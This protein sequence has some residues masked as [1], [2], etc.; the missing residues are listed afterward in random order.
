MLQRSSALGFMARSWWIADT[1]YHLY[2]WISIC[3]WLSIEWSYCPPVPR[4]FNGCRVGVRARTLPVGTMTGL[5]GDTYHYS[6][7]CVALYLSRIIIKAPQ[8]KQLKLLS[9]G[10]VCLRVSTAYSAFPFRH[11]SKNTND[12][13]SSKWSWFLVLLRFIYVSKS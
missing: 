10:S 12:V 1:F 9:R 11:F 7:V 3:I 4:V 13:L 5:R 6:P 8:Q 2:Y